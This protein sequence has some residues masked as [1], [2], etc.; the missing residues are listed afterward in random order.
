MRIVKT[1]RPLC[2]LCLTLNLNGAILLLSTAV[3]ACAL[4]IGQITGDRS[5]M[6][7]KYDNGAGTA[8]HL[9]TYYFRLLADKAGVM[10]DSDND[11]EVRQIVDAL[12]NAAHEDAGV[13]IQDALN[14]HTASEWHESTQDAELE[15]ACMDYAC[16]D[17]GAIGTAIEG[18]ACPAC[19]SS[20]V[21]TAAPGR[22]VALWQLRTPTTQEAQQ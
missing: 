10:W 4:R 17:C 5:T 14:E 3:L 8:K 21:L 22:L 18:D 20:N 15:Y 11:S 19:G 1:M 9:L 12:L 13:A 16:A 7:D 2:A 6:T